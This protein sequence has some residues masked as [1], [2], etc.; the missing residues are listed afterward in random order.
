[1]KRAKDSA[2][3]DAQG[4]ILSEMFPPAPSNPQTVDPLDST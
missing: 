3:L 1:M 4:S 2:A